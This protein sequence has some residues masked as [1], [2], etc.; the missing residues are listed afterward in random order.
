[1]NKKINQSILRNYRNYRKK[2][3]R[4]GKFFYFFNKKIF[5]V[6][7]VFIIKNFLG[8]ITFFDTTNKPTIMQFLNFDF[9]CSLKIN[10]RLSFI[11]LQLINLP[12]FYFYN[13]SS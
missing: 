7:K 10:S 3:N 4:C 13:A 1:M 6:L 2:V 9:Y 8:V 12:C 11:K 5:F